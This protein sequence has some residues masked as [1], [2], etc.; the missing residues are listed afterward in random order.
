[1][2]EPRCMYL[3]GNG[4]LR[5]NHAA[6]VSSPSNFERQSFLEIL[7]KR[8]RQKNSRKNVRSNFATSNDRD[9]KKDRNSEKNLIK[10]KRIC[11]ECPWVKSWHLY[12]KE[13]AIQRIVTICP[14]ACVPVAV[15]TSHWS[16]RSYTFHWCTLLSRC[17]LDCDFRALVEK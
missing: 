11:F 9:P 6:I 1:M 13:G 8:G 2:Y 3:H 17:P 15:N 10:K 16:T 12:V 14:D 7:V 5:G 4:D